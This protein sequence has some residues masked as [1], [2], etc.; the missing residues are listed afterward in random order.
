LAGTRLTTFFVDL[1]AAFLDVF[2]AALDVP[3]APLRAF[4]V[5]PEAAKGFN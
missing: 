4:T 5:F 3:L 2:L 1:F